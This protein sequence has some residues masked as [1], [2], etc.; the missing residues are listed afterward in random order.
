MI[1]RIDP[2]AVVGLELD[3][4]DLAATRKRNNFVSHTLYEVIRALGLVQ[5]QSEPA[6]L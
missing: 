2:S 1:R 4:G 5:N 3:P 6:G